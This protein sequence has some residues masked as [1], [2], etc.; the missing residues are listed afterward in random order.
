VR[1]LR[2]YCGY[3]ATNTDTYCATISAFVELF[4]HYCGYFTTTARLRYFYVPVQEFRMI[5]H[6]SSSKSS[7]LRSCWA[8]DTCGAYVGKAGRHGGI[9]FSNQL[10]VTTDYL[11]DPAWALH[12]GPQMG[13]PCWPHGG[14]S[15]VPKDNLIDRNCTTKLSLYFLCMY[16]TCASSG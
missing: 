13:T 9:R 3:Y 12:H 16:R 5:Q 2:N 15:C 1:L 14:C 6:V 8:W 7:E 10:E 11:M 4:R